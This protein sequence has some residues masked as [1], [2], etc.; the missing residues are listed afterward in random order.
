MKKACKT[1][2]QRERNK[3]RSPSRKKKRS[4]ERSEFHRLDKQGEDA[5]TVLSIS[6]AAALAIDCCTLLNICWSSPRGKQ[7]DQCADTSHPASYLLPVH[8]V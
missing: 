3:R 8:S 5:V 4:E 2:L 6:S 7:G 1:F